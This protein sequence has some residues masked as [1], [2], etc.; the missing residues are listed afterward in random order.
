M[1]KNGVIKLKFQIR[2]PNFIEFFKL[3]NLKNFSIVTL[4]DD[5]FNINT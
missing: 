4:A 1:K 2:K 3:S 5:V